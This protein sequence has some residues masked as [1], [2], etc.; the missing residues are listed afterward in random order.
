MNRAAC[1]A[2]C[3]IHVFCT[4]IYETFWLISA[5]GSSKGNTLLYNNNGG[6][7]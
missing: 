6:S 5:K 3:P 4:L 1:D 2:G 7:Q